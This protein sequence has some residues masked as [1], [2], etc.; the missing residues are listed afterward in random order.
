MVYATQSGWVVAF[1]DHRAEKEV[2]KLA[3]D[4]RAY[5]ERI[6]DLIEQYG[7]EQVHE[8]Y[9]KHISGKIWE[10]R[11]K[12]RD[13]IAR[14]LYVTTVGKRVW[15]LHAFVKKT[16]KT[17]SEAIDLAKRRAKELGLL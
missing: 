1:A 11:A 15:I 5:L 6:T 13:G 2:S 16:N 4:V 12:G 7:L 17:R 8:P 9:V 14:A 3:E 10:I